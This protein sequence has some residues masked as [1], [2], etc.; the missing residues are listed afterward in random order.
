[1]YMTN[2]YFFKFKID[3]KYVYKNLTTI[4]YYV[5]TKQG[6]FVFHLSFFS[7]GVLFFWQDV[8]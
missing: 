8:K 4:Q 6:H 7:M 5:Y 1:M 3:S 2:K